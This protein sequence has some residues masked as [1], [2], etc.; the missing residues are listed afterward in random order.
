[1]SSGTTAWP[2]RRT[3][4]LGRPARRHANHFKSGLKAGEQVIVKGLQ[5]VRPGQKVEATAEPDN[6]A[7]NSTVEAAIDE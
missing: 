1:M 5:R 6:V 7:A 2:Q 3:V 4:E